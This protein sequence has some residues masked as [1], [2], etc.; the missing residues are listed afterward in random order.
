[1]SNV[2]VPFLAAP[3]VAVSPLSRIRRISRRM[4]VVCQCL[5][6]A[7]PLALLWHWATASEADLAMH[8]NLPPSAIQSPLLLWQR[9]AGAAASAVPL[10]LMLLGVWQA[11]Q[12]FALFA[13]GQVFTA[14]AT[15][16]LRSLAGWV[17]WAALAAILSGAVV[18]VLLTLGNPP[19]TR[20]LV[21]GLGFDHVL[22]LFFAALVWL[23]ADVIGQGELLAHENEQF[24]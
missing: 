24:V 9:L 16:Y 11:R 21:V 13:S 20:H 3:P 4:V 2:P 23:I 8:S 10:G 18:S 6:V 12:C 5:L 1:M 7:L 22:T 14:R 17:A 15:A 19:G